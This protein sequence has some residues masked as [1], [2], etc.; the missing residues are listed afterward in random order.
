[1]LGPEQTT[2]Y[3]RTAHGRHL[4]VREREELVKPFLPPPS[5]T[6]PDSPT[7]EPGSLKSSSASTSK[8]SRRPSRIRPFL[9][10]Q[11]HLVIFTL[12]HLAFSIY[13]RLRQTYHA[14]LDRIFAVL[15]YHHRTPELIRRDVKGL[16]RLPQHLSV[17][18]E[19]ND[20]NGPT[21][22]RRRAR[23]DTVGIEKLMDETAEI[24]A[25]C[26][27]VGIP[28]LSVYEKTGALKGYIPTAQKAVETKFRAYFGDGG[29]TLTLKVPGMSSPMT[30]DASDEEPLAAASPPNGHLTILLLSSEDSRDALVDLTK[31]LT[32][33][34]Q[35]AKLSPSDISTPL[36]DAEVCQAVS[37]DPD[38]LVLFGPRVRLEGY[39]VW[40]LRLT[41]IL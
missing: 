16:S 36:I 26:A 31:T 21:P 7:A 20:A 1:M 9:R 18:L 30:S 25:W 13:V 28:T 40:L 32:E 14:L 41:E 19:L 10:S 22:R 6:D 15:Y 3:R 33:M 29:P 11:L 17:I 37:A 4:D 24:A 38:L 23:R 35:R 12:I 8:R 2:V 39:P 5:P 34:S 27:C